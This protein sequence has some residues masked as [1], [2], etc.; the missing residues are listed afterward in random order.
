MRILL[1]HRSTLCEFELFPNISLVLSVEFHNLRVIQI[2]PVN[3]SFSCYNS[4][5]HFTCSPSLS[6]LLWRRRRRQRCCWWP[7]QLGRRV[8][9]SKGNYSQLE[10]ETRLSLTDRRPRSIDDQSTIDRRTELFDR[11]RSRPFD[12]RSRSIMILRP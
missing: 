4:V 11:S 3:F 7:R 8:P 10:R 6:L 12:D 9:P 1:L 2:T 5:V